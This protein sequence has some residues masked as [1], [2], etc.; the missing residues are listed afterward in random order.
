MYSEGDFTMRSRFYCIALL[1]TTGILAATA[2]AQE[3][4]FLGRWALTPASGGAG[5]LEVRTDAGYLDGTLLWMGGSPEPQT[6]VYLDGDTLCALRIRDNEIKDAEGKVVRTQ[7]I[8]IMLTATLA[9]DTLRGTLTEPSGDGSSVSKQAFTGARIPPLPPAPDL[10]SVKFGAP[11]ELFNGKSLDGWVVIGGP[12]WAQVKS[13]RPGAGA[14]EGWIPTDENTANGWFVK[15]GIL[16]NDPVQKE[17]QPHIRYGNLATA[18]EFEDFNLT[19][20]VNVP[21]N[22]NSG[23]YLRGIYEVQ[24]VD[25]YGKPLDRHNMGS[26]Y[27]RI[28][29]TMSAEKPAGEWQK[30]DITLL[31]RHVTVKLNGQTII[32]NLP[33]TGCTGGALWSDESLPGPI[34]LQGDHTGVQYRNIVLRPILK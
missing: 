13:Q 2:G 8:P 21:A 16:I 15:D 23:I 33:L 10:S 9:G 20:D 26:I 14:V 25:S 27:G 19:L 1:L 17:G 22:G 5:W 7:V 18:G 4:P 3:N 28:A 24:V 34:Y 6:R 32:D 31:D 11:V 29:P 30:V 12:H